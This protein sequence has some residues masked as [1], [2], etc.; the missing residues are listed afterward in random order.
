MG[1]R[2]INAI[3]S[4]SEFIGSA[5]DVCKFIDGKN[6]HIALE[7]VIRGKNIGQEKSGALSEAIQI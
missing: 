6:E 2:Y 4:I 3:A 5:H 1:A 7:S